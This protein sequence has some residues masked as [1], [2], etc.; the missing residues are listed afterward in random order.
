MPSVGIWVSRDE[1]H[2]WGEA[3][4]R[5]KELTTHIADMLEID[6]HKR[7][8]PPPPGREGGGTLPHR[9]PGG[10][11]YSNRVRGHSDDMHEW[12]IYRQNINAGFVDNALRNK[13]TRPYPYGEFRLD[14]TTISTLIHAQKVDSKLAVSRGDGVD[15]DMLINFGLPRPGVGR[16][17]YYSTDV[18]QG[19]GGGME[20][21]NLRRARSHP[22]NVVVGD[23]AQG[24][25]ASS[26]Y[27]VRRGGGGGGRLPDGRRPRAHSVD[28]MLLE[29]EYRYYGDQQRGTASAYGGFTRDRSP[30]PG[31]RLSAQRRTQS[32][33][34]GLDDARRQEAARGSP[35]YRSTANLVP[36]AEPI[37][38]AYEKRQQHDAAFEQTNGGGRYDDWTLSKGAVTPVPIG[39]MYARNDWYWDKYP[40]TGGYGVYDI[41]DV[42]DAQLSQYPH[43]QLRDVTSEV[44]T[45]SCCCCCKTKHVE[46]ALDGITFELHGGELLAILGSPHSGKTALLEMMS[47]HRPPGLRYFGEVVVNGVLLQLKHLR[48]TVAYVRKEDL[49]ISYLT[50]EQF[51]TLFSRLKYSRS[52]SAGERRKMASSYSGKTA[53]LEMMSGHRPPGLRYFGE[54]VVNGVLLQLKHLRETVAYVRKEDLLVSYLTVEQFITLFSRLKYSR[55]SSAG[56]RRKMVEYYIDGAQLQLY[57]KRHISVI[58]AEQKKLV[59][60]VCQ[61]MLDTDI[62]LLDEPT[63]GLEPYW[64]MF[65]TDFI[66]EYADRGRIAI[67]TMDHPNLEMF[68]KFTKVAILSD[69]KLVY[70][71]SNKDLLP[72]F[73]SSH[74]PCPPLTNPCDYY[75]DLVTIDFESVNATEE[76]MD[77]V[78][79]LAAHQRQRAP[80]ISDPGPP[81]T[82][83]T[84]YRN[85]NWFSQFFLLCRLM[86]LRVFSLDTV[87]M[88]VLAAV[89]S[90]LVGLIFSNIDLIV[91]GGGAGFPNLS[92]LSIDGRFG[93]AFVMLAITTL[94]ELNRVTGL[95][96]EERPGLYA[97][98]KLKMFHTVP[99]YCAKLLLDLC[100]F[101]LTALTYCIP[102]YW[103][104]NYK[105]DAASFGLYLGV[106]VL[107]LYSIRMMAFA[108]AYMFTK[109]P[110]AARVVYLSLA[111]VGV[112]AG[113]IVHHDHMFKVFQWESNSSSTHWAYRLIIQR[114]MLTDLNF[115]VQTICRQV[116]N[117]TLVNQEVPLEV[118]DNT[119]YTPPGQVHTGLE[120]LVWHGRDVVFATYIPWVIIA[121]FALLFMIGGCF[122]LCIFSQKPTNKEKFYE[123]HPHK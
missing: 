20:E 100:P 85:A 12:S 21:S 63:S 16:S 95:I 53:L 64:A 91:R 108:I 92:Q 115:K 79:K 55:S 68:R 97:G 9:P 65:V 17:R 59:S 120:A 117:V 122:I 36:N 27:D 11:D 116:T 118:L 60:I 69:G 106:M 110:Y 38:N 114:E 78:K 44:H 6:G 81:H 109:G 70:Y 113:Y 87:W 72:Y 82:L 86:A 54:V 48:E 5:L 40:P 90:V 43:L 41:G 51:I 58:P 37:S 75:V 93:F 22:E 123:Q 101:V 61:L 2:F 66:R 107:Y 18:I 102:A 94:P 14:P 30:S 8:L 88:F 104:S 96:D 50:V 112:A 7:Y 77:R 45:S 84:K 99:Y 105:R 1:S 121:A 4:A 34:G 15:A 103:L 67:A 62:M 74:Y 80:P 111:Y 49:L 47:G 35:D 10:S 29:K 26:Q 19:G 39:R 119:C 56:E 24:R 76:S 83:P 71:G 73:T 52:S 23:G 3:S 31:G 13:R 32:A 28:D 98:Q 25:V 57:R 89:I 46:R 42:P 33:Y